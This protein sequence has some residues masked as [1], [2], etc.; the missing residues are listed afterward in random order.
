MYRA[1][2][3]S[4]HGF[5]IVVTGLCSATGSGQTSLVPL[6][7][8][9]EE[10]RAK[11][12][13]AGNGRFLGVPGKLLGADAE[14]PEEEE[15]EEAEEEEPA[16]EE[17]EEELE[18]EEGNPVPR[19]A[20]PP[21]AAKVKPVRFSEAHRLAWTVHGEGL[22][23]DGGPRRKRLN[24]SDRHRSLL[25]LLLLRPHPVPLLPCPRAPFVA[26][27][28]CD[29]SLVPAGAFLVSPNRTIE[30][31]PSFGGVGPSACGGLEPLLHFRPPRDPARAQALARGSLLGH[32]A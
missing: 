17:G 23:V 30:P 32:S 7:E 2:K 18:V 24:R 12:V 20:A 16:A 28:A 6:P 22:T 1:L 27:I 13:A 3:I 29:T 8:I 10:H 26:A 9:V 21:R 25:S 14:A 4:A 31:N 19:H 5:I 15:E 11:N